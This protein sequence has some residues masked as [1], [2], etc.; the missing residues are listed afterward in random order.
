MGLKE[1][2]QGFINPQP[3]KPGGS[4]HL[5]KTTDAIKKRKKRVK[6]EMKK[7]EK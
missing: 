7:L 3:K 6:E 4:G 2:W 1:I 5:G